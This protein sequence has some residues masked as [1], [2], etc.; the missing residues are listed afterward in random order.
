[1][2]LG[3]EEGVS[4]QDMVM[5]GLLIPTGLTAWEGLDNILDGFNCWTYVSLVLEGTTLLLACKNKMGHPRMI[6]IDP[7]FEPNFQLKT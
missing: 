3:G 7:L 2:L 4:V 5:I 1:M 6:F